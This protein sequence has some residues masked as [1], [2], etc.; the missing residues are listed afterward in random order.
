MLPSKAAPVNDLSPKQ[1][2]RR[3]VGREAWRALQYVCDFSAVTSRGAL[4]EYQEVAIRMLTKFE[5][6]H[7][8]PHAVIFVT[9]GGQSLRGEIAEQL[10]ALLLWPGWSSSGA[11]SRDSGVAPLYIDGA[12]PLGPPHLVAA[13]V[14]AIELK[15]EVISAAADG[16]VHFAVDSRHAD[17][18]REVQDADEAFVIYVPWDARAACAPATDYLVQENGRLL[19]GALQSKAQRDAR[20]YDKQSIR[21]FG[22]DR[23]ADGLTRLVSNAWG[24]IMAPLFGARPFRKGWR[25]SALT[26]YEEPQSLLRKQYRL[27]FDDRASRDAFARMVSHECGRHLLFEC[28][29]V[30]VNG[31]SCLMSKRGDRTFIICVS[32]LPRILYCPDPHKLIGDLLRWCVGLRPAAKLDFKV[33]R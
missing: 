1:K 5:S 15:R 33:Q 22:R 32:T 6:L 16:V 27:E 24:A 28:D 13:P 30:G 17:A 21:Q 20:H 10:A 12:L 8:K 29:E 9:G 31:L 18:L 23:Q 7:G 11:P 14:E 19:R 3:Q 2:A 26:A 25:L 4:P